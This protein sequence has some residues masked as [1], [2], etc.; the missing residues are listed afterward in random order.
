[1]IELTQQ[2]LKAMDAE[3][4]PRWIDP[5]TQKTFVLVGADQY[6][7]LR[8]LLNSDE[9]LTMPQVAALVEEAMPEDDADDPTLAVYQEKYGRKP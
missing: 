4:E 1:M 7:R 5:R 9:G 3:P 2:Q 8:G 6:E